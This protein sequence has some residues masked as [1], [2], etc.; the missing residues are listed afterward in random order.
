M[1]MARIRAIVP[2]REA[3]EANRWLRPFARGVLQPE[4]WRFTR[5]SVPRGIALGFFLGV[6]IPFA[7]SVLA[8]LLAVVVRANVPV[9]VT[10]TWISNPFTWLVMWPLAYRL[11]RLLLQM[12]RLVG[13]RPMA[14][15]L[16]DI[17]ARAGGGSG[18]GRHHQ[19]AARASEVGLTMA[20]GLL[21]EAV[22]LALAGYLVASMVW[23]LRVARRRRGRLARALLARV[24]PGHGSDPEGAQAEGFGCEGAVSGADVAD[25]D[26]TGRDVTGQNVSGPLAPDPQSPDPQRI[27][28]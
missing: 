21:A 12:D 17:A 26:M 5:R 27:E 13:L 7:H 23:R 11:G 28:A 16:P 18:W 20:C 25:S 22:L 14:E 6:L 10:A 19:F 3:L 24:L 9:A 15:A 1:T 8:A 2:S 4:L